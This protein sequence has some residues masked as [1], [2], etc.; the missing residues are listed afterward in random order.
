MAWGYPITHPTLKNGWKGLQW[1]CLFATVQYGPWQ[2]LVN[3]YAVCEG[4]IE[5]PSWI[6]VIPLC[7]SLDYYIWLRSV[8][9]CP[10]RT[11]AA[12][13]CIHEIMRIPL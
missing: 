9:Y 2:A 3:I 7:T 5:K 12:G 1:D 13:C 4:F 11:L 8:V 6:C 10:Q